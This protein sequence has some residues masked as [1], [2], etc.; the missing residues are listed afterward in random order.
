MIKRGRGRPPCRSEEET[1][2]LV[3]EA[4][5][6]EFQA[7]GYANTG[8]DKIAERA[9]VSTR[10][11]Y[12]LGN[13]AELFAMVVGERAGGFIL[14]IDEAHLEEL[15]P[16]EAL[17]RILTNYGK[18]TLAPE[19]IAIT[20]LVIA[21]GGRFPEIGEAFYKQAVKKINNVIEHW[22]MQQVEQGRLKLDDPA[23]AAGMLRGMMLME[24]QR[25]VFVGKTDVPSHAEIEAR[26]KACAVL[27]VNGCKP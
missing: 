10:T 4:A 12:Q 6:A 27:F 24:P 11:I 15:E 9:G 2:K 1:L 13:K 3:T 5:A 21:E 26:A 25:L 7:N 23:L 16:V 22:L 19:T 14:T 20:R 8:V 17:S 18:L